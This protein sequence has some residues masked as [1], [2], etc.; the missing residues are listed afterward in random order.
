[1]AG[2]RVRSEP[3]ISVT[4]QEAAAAEAAAYNDKNPGWG[5]VGWVAVVSYVPAK[6]NQKAGWFCELVRQS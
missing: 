6:G 4:T 3:T 2:Y 5:W 1:M